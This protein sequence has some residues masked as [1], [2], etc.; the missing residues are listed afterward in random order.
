MGQDILDHHSFPAVG[1]CPAGTGLRANGHA[2]DRPAI[3]IG[4]INGIGVE[5]PFARFVEDHDRQGRFRPDV[6]DMVG[7]GLQKLLDAGGGRNP[8]QHL[9]A[10]GQQEYRHLALVDVDMGAGHPFRLAGR[11]P[12]DHFA[13]A[14]DPA[15]AARFGAHQEFLFELRRP[16]GPIVLNRRHDLSL[17]VG[18]QQAEPS[19]RGR[20]DLAILVS[21]HLL[22]AIIVDD[23][24][25]GDMPIPETV[26]AAFHHPLQPRLDDPARLFVFLALGDVAGESGGA[27]QI[28]LVVID[29]GLEGLNPVCPGFAGDFLLGPFLLAG[30]HDQPVIGDIAIGKLLRPDVEIGL[31]LQFLL[32]ETAGF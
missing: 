12:V 3:E 27:Q 14:E 10:G 22:P 23:P 25:G 24:S 9:V 32:G 4:K 30:F 13:A 1:G 19:F 28:P 5:Q 8:F 17:V 20:F 7:K 6:A 15:P 2:I 26:I 31:P 16:A 29:G 11:H 18:M 21:Q